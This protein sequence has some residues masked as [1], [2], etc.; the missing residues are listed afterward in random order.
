VK[1]K[2]PTAPYFKGLQD[3]I[4]PKAVSVC[5]ADSRIPSME[6]PRRELAAHHTNLGRQISIQ[7][8]DPRGK[9]EPLRWHVY[10]GDLA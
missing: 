5:F 3:K 4:A 8:G 7:S 6:I 9:G 2:V 1:R 10:V